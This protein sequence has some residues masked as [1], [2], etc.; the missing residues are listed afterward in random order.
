MLTVR[1]EISVDDALD[2]ACLRWHRTQDAWDMIVW[3]LNH[4]PTVGEPVA[5]GGLARS[6]VFD[7][8]WAHDMPTIQILYIVEDPYVPIKAAAFRD[9]TGSAGTA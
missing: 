5:E 1:Q 2:D 9:P 8:S 3:V 4:D 7:G 6:L